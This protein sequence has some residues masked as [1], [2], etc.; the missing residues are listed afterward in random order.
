MTNLS[1][2]VLDTGTEL[3]MEIA[4]WG[5]LLLS[6]LIAVLWLVYVYR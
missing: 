4:G 1:T 5:V 3:P 2:V 6:L